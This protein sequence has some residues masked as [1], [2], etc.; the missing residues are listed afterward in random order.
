[1]TKITYAWE[2]FTNTDARR[3]NIYQHES[4]E[5]ELEDTI[6]VKKMVAGPNY[7]MPQ[8]RRKL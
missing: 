5:D 3:S 6:V 7:E 2:V 4:F 1:M 8:W